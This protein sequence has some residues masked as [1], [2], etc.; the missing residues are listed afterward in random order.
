MKITGGIAGGLRID[1]PPGD[2]TRPTTDRVRE[3]VFSILRD[4]LPGAVVLDL[5]A[6]S[7]SLGL[8]AASRGAA[9]VLWVEKHPATCEMIRN[10]AARLLPA[11][12]S[13]KTR[14]DCAEVSAWLRRGGHPTADLIFADPPYADFRNPTA[15]SSFLQAVR[16]AG[17]LSEVGLLALE[18][19]TRLHPE[20]PEGW[21][22]LRRETYG[23]SSVWML[24]CKGA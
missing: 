9:E 5:F 11:G 4:L 13:A 7:G 17:I 1:A 15:F 24:E 2:R 10:N 14:V 3:S 18:M 6:G 8:E 22:M 21:E 12:V 16:D 23:T 20:L 19:S